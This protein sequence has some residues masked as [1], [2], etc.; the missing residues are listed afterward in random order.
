MD[1]CELLSYEL[2]SE[3]T[4]REKRVKRMSGHFALLRGVILLG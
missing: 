3:L 2:E 1:V 4:W